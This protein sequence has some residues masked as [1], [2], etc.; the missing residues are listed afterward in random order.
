MDA[1]AVNQQIRRPQSQELFRVGTGKKTVEKDFLKLKN[2]ENR[3]GNADINKRILKRTGKIGNEET[4]QG[5]METYLP[6]LKKDDSRFK[7]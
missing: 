1:S 6:E 4:S 7:G 2:M 3:G 5:I